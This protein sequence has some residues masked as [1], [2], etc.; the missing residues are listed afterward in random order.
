MDEQSR[1]L[2]IEI[3]KL[4]QENNSML[5]SMR[6]AERNGRMFK[7]IYW[8]IVLGLTYAAYIYAKPYM[9]QA[10]EF[11]GAAQAQMQVVKNMQNVMQ[12]SGQ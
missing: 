10:K 8:I 12:S 2:L 11:Y 7:A 4:S 1:G 3:Q 9:E 6:R 5:K